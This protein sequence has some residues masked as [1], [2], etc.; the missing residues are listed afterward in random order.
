MPLAA[1]MSGTLDEGYVFYGPFNGIESALDWGR[2]ECHQATLEYAVT[3]ETPKGPK[4]DYN[5]D[6]SYLL[7]VGQPTNGYQFIGPFVDF[8]AADDYSKEHFGDDPYTWIVTL[9]KPE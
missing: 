8:D 1:V 5:A 2:P 7:C 6:Y 3:L 4:Q 9:N